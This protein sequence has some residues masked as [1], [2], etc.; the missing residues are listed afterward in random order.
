MLKSLQR[1]WNIL[2]DVFHSDPTPP[3]P[4]CSWS[5]MPEQDWPKGYDPITDS[6]P[7]GYHRSK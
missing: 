3:F 1:F 6:F 7:D 5:E 2:T 4:L